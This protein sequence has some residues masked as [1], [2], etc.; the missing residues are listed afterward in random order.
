MFESGLR[1]DAPQKESLAFQGLKQ[2]EE[3]Q[4]S[5]EQSAALDTVPLESLF[6]GYKLGGG[7]HPGQKLQQARRKYV[8]EA[9]MR[10]MN[11]HGR[12]RNQVPEEIR[13][14]EATWAP[15]HELSHYLSHQNSLSSFL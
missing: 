11:R 4:A 7:A 15:T 8:R 6:S 10:V 1:S 13:H 5:S 2:I 12:G 3:S 9:L 14:R